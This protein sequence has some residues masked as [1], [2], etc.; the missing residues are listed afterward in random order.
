MITSEEVK[1]LQAELTE[2]YS[3][4]ALDLTKLR[5]FA[6]MLLRTYAERY[7]VDMSG[8]INLL[9]QMIEDKSEAVG[10]SGAE[11]REAHNMLIRIARTAQYI[12]SIPD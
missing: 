9:E 3:Q 5:M 6:P 2:R 4:E 8:P 7:G 10:L 11:I 12:N 1:R